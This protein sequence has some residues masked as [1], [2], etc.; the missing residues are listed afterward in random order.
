MVPH[1]WLQSLYGFRKSLFSSGSAVGAQ[2]LTATDRAL[3]RNAWAGRSQPGTAPQDEGDPEWDSPASPP[4]I[5]TVL[6]W[7]TGSRAATRT[8]ALPSPHPPMMRM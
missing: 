3:F 6:S 7:E 4:D 2:E 8:Q 5:S 1:G